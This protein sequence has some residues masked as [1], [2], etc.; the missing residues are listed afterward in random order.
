MGSA[1]VTDSFGH[2]CA[3]VW[4]LH[5]LQL[6]LCS[7]VGC[8]GTAASHVLEGNLLLS[9]ILTPLSSCDCCCSAVL[10]LLSHVIPE[11][12]PLLLLQ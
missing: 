7:A 4:I 10:P 9:H 5:G 2:S 12:L 11:V 3:P 8:S 1:H 6:D